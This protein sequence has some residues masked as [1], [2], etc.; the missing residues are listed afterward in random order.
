MSC[1][2]W[3]SR[4]VVFTVDMSTELQQDLMLV[5]CKAGLVTNDLEKIRGSWKL[6]RNKW[7]KERIR[8]RKVW[9]LGRMEAE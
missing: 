6:C 7:P 8:W 3:A 9:E 4:S 5:K 1:R 2:S